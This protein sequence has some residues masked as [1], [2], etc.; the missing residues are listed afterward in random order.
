MNRVALISITLFT[1]ALACMFFSLSVYIGITDRLPLDPSLWPGPDD[2]NSQ[3][4]IL[5]VL[6]TIPAGT[7]FF[8]LDRLW[9]FDN[10]RIR[11]IFKNMLSGS[12]LTRIIVCMWA[13]LILLGSGSC[14]GN[15][16]VQITD[17]YINPSCFYQ[18][19]C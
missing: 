13:T 7:Y 18:S 12:P 16:V 14:V 3:S 2:T 8:M 15:M 4:Q 5:W 6:A 19:P 9:V 10:I 11:P 17:R 1:G